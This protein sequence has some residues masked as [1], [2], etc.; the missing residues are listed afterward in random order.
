LVVEL[1]K[2]EVAGGD[3]ADECGHHRPSVLFGAQQLGAGG[4]GRTP[5]AAPE[6]QFEGKQVESGRPESSILRRDERCRQGRR[7]IPG[8]SNR[9][10]VRGGIQVRE[11]LGPGNAEIGARCLDAGAASR[12]S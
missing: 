1:T 7:A 9:R 12:R 3:F 10:D 6:V 5:Q 11:L 2:A 8:N 4:F